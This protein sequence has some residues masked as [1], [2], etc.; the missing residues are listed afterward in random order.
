VAIFSKLRT[1]DQVIAE[2]SYPVELLANSQLGGE[3]AMPDFLAA[4]CMPNDPSTWR[5]T[6][7]LLWLVSPVQSTAGT[8]RCDL[9]SRDPQQNLDD[10]RCPRGHQPTLRRRGARAND[11][12]R[13][14]G[15]RE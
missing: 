15:R 10:G 11:W 7:R 8:H 1:G 9:R 6:L 2:T 3:Q 4:F 12:K 14:T 5:M 13:L